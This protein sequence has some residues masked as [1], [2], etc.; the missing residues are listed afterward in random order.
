L[1]IGKSRRGSECSLIHFGSICSFPSL[2][3]QAIRSAVY[4]A[5]KPNYI[6]K[7]LPIQEIIMAQLLFSGKRPRYSVA[8][9]GCGFEEI[10]SLESRKILDEEF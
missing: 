8:D 5:N 7:L 6:I 1:S 10:G 3:C 4:L 2:T 9:L